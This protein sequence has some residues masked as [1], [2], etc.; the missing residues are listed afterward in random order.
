MS[1]VNRALR[2]ALPLSPPNPLSPRSLLLWNWNRHLRGAIL[3]GLRVIDAPALSMKDLYIDP[4]DQGLPYRRRTGEVKSCEHFGQRKLLM[5]EIVFLTRF[6]QR[7]DMLVYAGAAMGFHIPVLLELFPEGYFSRVVLVDP[8]EFCEE[9][10]GMATIE[11]VR[12]LFTTEMALGF[13]LEAR[14]A[15]HAVLFLS[16]VR[17]P[18][19]HVESSRERD[20]IVMAD[21]ALQRDWV[22]AMR[23]KAAMLKFRLPY[24]SGKSRYLSGELLLPVWGGVTT[25]EARLIVQPADGVEDVEYDHDLHSNRMFRFNTV[26]RAMVS[27]APGVDGLVGCQLDS[28][29][30]CSAEAIILSQLIER[31]FADDLQRTS[32]SLGERVAELS[33][34]IDFRLKARSP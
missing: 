29:F 12:D 8:S 5:G 31:G 10:R 17:T 20:S 25:S 9:V 19:V 4:E 6:S 3:S 28:C 13:A 30:D 2:A 18:I 14:E 32:G 15:G 16:D 34:W 27:Y 24:E 21:M 1:S 33:A 11:I 22:L 7:G 26:T 23:P